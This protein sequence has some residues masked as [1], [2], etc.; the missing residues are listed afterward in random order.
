MN[1]QHPRDSGAYVE[2]TLERNLEH[3]TNG[4]GDACMH[5]SSCI[6]D[7][8]YFMHIKCMLASNILL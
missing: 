6:K 3:V 4:N 7:D 1:I 2:S 8:N 5:K